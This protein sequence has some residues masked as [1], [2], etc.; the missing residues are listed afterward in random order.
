MALS[1]PLLVVQGGLLGG[2]CAVALVVTDLGVVGPTAAARTV[3]ALVRSS[4]TQRAA[5]ASV[6]SLQAL[7]VGGALMGNA[8]TFVAPGLLY[9]LLARRAAK[10]AAPRAVRLTAGAMLGLGVLLVPVTLAAAFA[11]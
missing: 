8:L 6:R 1:P 3:V 4:S 10:D 9:L 11:S 5:L 7:E 2:T